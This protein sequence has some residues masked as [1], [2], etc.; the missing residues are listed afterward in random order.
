LSKIFWKRKKKSE[1]KAFV[2]II[3]FIVKIKKIP[4]IKFELIKDG[5]KP[6][7]PI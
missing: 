7:S 1:N 5:R 6:V 2:R 3:D 4:D